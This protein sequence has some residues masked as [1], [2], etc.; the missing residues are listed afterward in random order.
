MRVEAMLRHRGARLVSVPMGESLR[1]TVALM[2]SEQVDAVVVTDRCATEGEAV[3]GLLTRGDVIDALADHGL[4]A[5]AMPVAKLAGGRLVMCDVGET[6]PGLIATMRERG[7][8]HALVM[9]REQ[10]VGLIDVSDILFFWQA[11][12]GPDH[13]AVH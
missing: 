3:L 12:A 11:M 13:A 10:A 2:R 1:S 5:F 9:D 8:G 7:A 6:V 4:A